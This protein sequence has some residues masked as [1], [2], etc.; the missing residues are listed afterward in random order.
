[1][2]RKTITTLAVAAATLAGVVMASPAQADTGCTGFNGYGEQLCVNYTV[3]NGSYT[4]I[5]ISVWG[6]STDY[7]AHVGSWSTIVYPGST[8]LY[9]GGNQSGTTVCVTE[10]TTHWNGCV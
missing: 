5:N 4:A 10:G 6:P 2:L 1:V 3:Y 9:V 7:R 8:T